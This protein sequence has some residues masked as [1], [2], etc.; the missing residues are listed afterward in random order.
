V[1]VED[2]IEPY[3]LMPVWSMDDM[4]QVRRTLSC[5]C[6]GFV[7][8]GWVC[9]HILATL[10][11]LGLFNLEMAM[12]RVAP[13]RGPGTPRTRRSALEAEDDYDG[14]FDCDRLLQRFIKQPGCPLGW[15]IV[16][17]SDVA[18]HTATGTSD[19][20]GVVAGDRLSDG[21]YVWS[22]RF[23]YQEFVNSRRYLLLQLPTEL[24]FLVLL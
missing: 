22:V 9:S 14:F 10:S 4:Q 6:G 15:R 12:A 24:T 11:I 20:V 18:T 5:T 1:K 7:R 2:R 13:R 23:G 3:V 17:D 21:V 16:A 19:F 8:S